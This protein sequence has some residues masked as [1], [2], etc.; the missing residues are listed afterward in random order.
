[1]AGSLAATTRLTTGQSIRQVHY[2]L[3]ELMKGLYRTIIKLGALGSISGFDID[4]GHFSGNECVSLLQCTRPH[5]VL[6]TLNEFD[7]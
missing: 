1:M 4:S 7:S 6:L 5:L 3:T 2:G